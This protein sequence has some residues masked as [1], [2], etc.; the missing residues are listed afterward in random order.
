MG[1]DRVVKPTKSNKIVKCTHVVQQE[2]AEGVPDGTQAMGTDCSPTLGDLMLAINNARNEMV[3]KIYPV[4][5]DVALLGMDLQ[6]LPTEQRK[7]KRW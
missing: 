5:I 3:V 1:K 4:A 6:K 7:R 2:E